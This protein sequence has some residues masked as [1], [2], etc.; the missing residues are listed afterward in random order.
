MSTSHR[1]R[2][3][4]RGLAKWKVT[5]VHKLLC[6]IILVSLKFEIAL[7]LDVAIYIHVSTRVSDED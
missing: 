7:S 2:S 4:G 5:N 1:G 6:L 3:D